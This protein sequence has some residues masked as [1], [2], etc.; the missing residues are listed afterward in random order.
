MGGFL[1]RPRIRRLVEL[2]NIKPHGR[3]RDFSPDVAQEVVTVLPF[4]CALARYHLLKALGFD[5]V[6]I[7]AGFARCR[8]GRFVPPNMR[9]RRE[10]NTLGIRT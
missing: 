1:G 3:G 5:R 7:A 9:F 4:L 6:A 10:R 8:Y 2:R